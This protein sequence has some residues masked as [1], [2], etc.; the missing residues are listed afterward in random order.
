MAPKSQTMIP[1]I[2]AELV[3]KIKS[4]FRQAGSESLVYDAN[5]HTRCRLHLCQFGERLAHP[6]QWVEMQPD[7]QPIASEGAKLSRPPRSWPK[8]L[9][10]TYMHIA[11]D[12]G[13]NLLACE[14]IRAGAIVDFR[15]SDGNT[16]LTLAMV[17]MSGGK[18]RAS[19]QLVIKAPILQTMARN[20]VY[21]YTF[22]V[23]IL[24]EQ[25]ADP[26]IDVQGMT[27]LHYACIAE[28]WDIIT[29][30]LEHGASSNP[31][32]GSTVKAPA[33]F[34]PPTSRSRFIKLAQSFANKPRPLRLCPCFSGLTTVA[35]HEEGKPYPPDFYC[36]CGSEK[37]HKH[38]CGRS[39]DKV[40][41]KWNN[42]TRKW[43]YVTKK[44]CITPVSLGGDGG[45]TEAEQEAYR[46]IGD[47]MSSVTQDEFAQLVESGFNPFQAMHE[48]IPQGADDLMSK[49]LIDPAF[50]YAMKKLVFFPR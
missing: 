26:N 30:L 3:D 48:V 28:D 19:R 1:Q 15:D 31:A 50:G 25:H 38:C 37:T 33:A 2:P 21:R 10:R 41:E 8:E 44:K 6:D 12:L 17:Q 14:M 24:L 49:G 42:T 40:S 7:V 27:P 47:F 36:H 11:A 13:D 32:L 22:L 43:E 23:R 39:A 18:K 9:K 35:C 34:L 4:D 29:L 16:A 45:A 20:Y 5:F 46:Q